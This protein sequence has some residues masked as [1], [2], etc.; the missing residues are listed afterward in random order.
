[1]AYK[2]TGPQFTRSDCFFGNGVSATQW[3]KH[4][5]TIISGYEYTLKQYLEWLDLLLMDDA[6]NWADTNSNAIRLLNELAPSQQTIIS[7]TS[8]FCTRFES[9]I[10]FHSGVRDQPP[11]LPEQPVIPLSEQPTLQLLEQPRNT[12]PEPAPELPK[13]P[14]LQLPEQPMP[15]IP[16]SA[17]S[18]PEQPAPEL[19]EQPILQLPEQPVISQ[20]AP[21][22]PQ[23]PTPQVPEQPTPQ[24]P[25]QPVVPEKPVIPEQPTLQLPKPTLQLPEQPPLQLSEQPMPVI[26][27]SAPSVPEQ[28]THLTQ[29]SV[30]T[31]HHWIWP[32]MGVG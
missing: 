8:L 25:E 17:P 7:F 29:Q 21:S 23:Q 16:Q 19:P 3:L 27:Q 26:P 11:Q 5:H 6:G 2:S 15:V 20:S 22:V 30:T 31:L 18:V 1:M 13:Q 10:E 4:F 14:P 28:L 9:L 24:V 32:I 12:L